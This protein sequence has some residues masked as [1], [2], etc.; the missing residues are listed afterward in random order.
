MSVVGLFGRVP[1]VC[2]NDAVLTFKDLS[3][4][5]TARWAKHDVIGKK[6][7]VEYIG[8]DLATVNFSIR[9]SASLGVQPLVALRE[10][11]N[12]LD[13]HRSER[14]IF[15][16]DPLGRFVLESVEEERRHHGKLGIC[17]VAEVRLT[18]REAQ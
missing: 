10:L 5:R 8:P 18:L 13:K 12:M 3:V 14:L 2:S 15:G 4:K 1:F 7:V 6:P 11:K 16:P 9:L 17:T